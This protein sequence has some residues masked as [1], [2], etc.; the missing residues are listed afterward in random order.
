M[1]LQL[2]KVRS[3]KGSKGVLL[4]EFSR[5][6]MCTFSPAP[7]ERRRPTQ[8]RPPHPERAH[9]HALRQWLF[10]STWARARQLTSSPS[11]VAERPCWALEPQDPSQHRLFTRTF[12]SFMQFL[13]SQTRSTMV[14][15]PSDLVFFF[16]DGGLLPS[17]LQAYTPGMQSSFAPPSGTSPA[18]APFQHRQDSPKTER[19]CCPACLAVAWQGY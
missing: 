5:V 19:Q 6:G 18:R 12:R 10:L 13:S 16:T 11:S 17:R 9:H 8:V 7:V 15:G 3:S 2:V 14:L 4:V 1:K